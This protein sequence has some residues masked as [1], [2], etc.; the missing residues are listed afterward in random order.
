MKTIPFIIGLIVG[1]SLYLGVQGFINSYQNRQEMDELY[2][3][4]GFLQKQIDE[5]SHKFDLNM[6]LLEQIEKDRKERW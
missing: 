2:A 5:M 3:Q 4:N 6:A 1:A